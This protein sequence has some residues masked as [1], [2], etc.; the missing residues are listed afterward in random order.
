MANSSGGFAP[1]QLVTVTE[2]VSKII[3]AA[4]STD[5]TTYTNAVKKMNTFWYGGDNANKMYTTLSNAHT[6]ISKNLDEIAKLNTELHNS[7]QK[8]MNA[9]MKKYGI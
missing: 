6:N 3:T 4:S 2:A 5:L 7:A 9:M 1:S 8:T